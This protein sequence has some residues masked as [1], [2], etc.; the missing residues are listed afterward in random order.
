MKAVVL[1]EF[2]EASNLKMESVPDPRPG[3]GEVL[4]RVEAVAVSAG[5]QHFMDVCI[6]RVHMAVLSARVGSISDNHLG[7]WHSYRAGKA[8]LNM[9]TRTSA[10]EMFETDEILM[11]AVFLW[12]ILAVTDERNE[13][14]VAMGPLAIGLALMAMLADHGEQPPHQPAARRGSAESLSGKAKPAIISRSS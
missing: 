4:I 11:T 6:S 3:R 1:R 10:R 8:A 12:V 5:K 2:G 9:L 13:V 7:G 14:N